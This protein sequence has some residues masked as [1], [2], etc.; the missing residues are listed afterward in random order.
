M[1]ESPAPGDAWKHVYR[2]PAFAERY[3]RKRAAGA[4]TRKREAREA[5]L[6]ESLLA[7]AALAPAARVLDCPAG[8]GRFTAQLAARGLRVTAADIALP[9]LAR[10]PG[11]GGRAVADALRLPFATG[12]FDLVLCVRL[13]H[14]VPTAAERARLFAELARVSRRYVLLSFFHRASFHELRDRVLGALRPFE[15]TRHATTRGEISREA[16]PHGLAVRASAPM[17]RWLKRPWFV[18]LERTGPSREVGSAP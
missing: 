8:T 7:R 2:D 9:M 18:L 13:L 17:L 4:S 15:K 11:E 10:V 3:A 1:S 6:V 16:A 12:A 5:A 14:H